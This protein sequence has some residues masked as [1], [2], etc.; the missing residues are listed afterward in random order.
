MRVH[1]FILKEQTEEIHNIIIN[2]GLN[3]H[4]Y[5]FDKS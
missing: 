2:E 1:K 5:Y 4:F 3:N